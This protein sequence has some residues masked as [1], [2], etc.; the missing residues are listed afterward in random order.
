MKENRLPQNG[1]EGILYGSVICIITVFI[2]LILNIGTS[3]GTLNQ[4]AV[5]VSILKAVPL[6]WVVAMLLESFVIGRLAEAF[7]NRF[8]E[9]S[10]GFNARIL[11]NILFVVLGMSV[12]M[13][14]IGPLISGEAFLDVV[15]A[16]PSH[17]PRNFCVAFWCEICLAQPVARKVM[18]LIHAGQEKHREEDTVPELIRR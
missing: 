10:D 4:K 6:I 11:F 14:V 5:W 12:S 8:S 2:M 18:K 1:K 13:T 9:T 17:W 3:F 15:L 7:V 16:F